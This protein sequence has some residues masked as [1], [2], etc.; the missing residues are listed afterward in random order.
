MILDLSQQK[1][2]DFTVLATLNNNRYSFAFTYNSYADFYSLLI[3]KNQNEII[4]SIKVVCLFDFNAY[5]R[6]L[7][8]PQ[9]NIIFD[10]PFDISSPQLNDFK[11]KMVVMNYIEA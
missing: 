5:F 11:N 4:L 7:D 8:I 6:H 3:S 10:T 9:G 1:K 2:N